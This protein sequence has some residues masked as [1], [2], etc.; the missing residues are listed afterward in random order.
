MIQT[1]SPP[2][3]D[4]PALSSAQLASGDVVGVAADAVI[5]FGVAA[6]LRGMAD[7]TVDLLANLTRTFGNDFPGKA[8]VE[9]WRG[10]DAPLQPLDKT[11]IELVTLMHN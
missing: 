5:A 10:A 9:K 7:T 3:G 4:I 2:R 11:V 8:V 1:T 6:A